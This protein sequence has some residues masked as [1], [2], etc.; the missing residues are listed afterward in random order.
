MKKFKIMLLAI[1]M[2]F[3][4]SFSAASSAGDVYAG[5]K[6]ETVYALLG[7]DGA[8]CGVYVVNS[9][10]TDS[11]CTVIDYGEYSEVKNLTAEAA[12]E[13][14]DGSVR[15]KTQGGK[16]SYQGNPVKK[17]IPWDISIKYF[18][19]GIEKKADELA[20][21]SGDIEIVIDIK[22]NN[23]VEK[24]FFENFTL[25][26]TAGLDT[27]LFSNI[28]A[29]GATVVNAG[30]HK[31]ITFTLLP[32][33]A[34]S[35][36]IKAQTDCFCL[37]PI[38]INGVLAKMPVELDGIDEMLGGIAGLAEGLGEVS[39]G[40]GRLKSGSAEFNDGLKEIASGKNALKDSSLRIKSSLMQ[41][42]SG[43]S[44]IVE[45]SQD[46]KA[47]AQQLAQSDD[48]L[49]STLAGGWLMQ[50]DALEELTQG[51][52]A[53]A[54]KYSEFDS[55][56]KSLSDGIEALKNSYARINKGLIALAGAL[57]EMNESAGKVDM[58]SGDISK[59]VSLYN[60]AYQPES[61]VSD[62]NSV[63]SVAFIMRTQA[64]DKPCKQAKAETPPERPNFWQKL[65]KLFR[66]S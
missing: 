41:A 54:S 8:V 40:A 22:K 27:E 43:L 65:L 57:E 11:P 25:Q 56:I 1:I 15:I 30:K 20:G 59:M 37:D 36:T 33:T 50:L 63:N 66:K 53:I 19:D 45:A 47:H 6:D 26:V 58:S 12:P 32:G 48:A 4:V 60:S 10:E 42:S 2:A 28:Q 39:K 21:E 14:S 16:I 9:F 34:K 7:H 24:K 23:E 38:Q 61:F 55:G 52:E 29:P 17:E 64:V 3:P 44:Q 62:K 51:L 13:Y 18:H 5:K 46:F 49:V 35:F 31:N